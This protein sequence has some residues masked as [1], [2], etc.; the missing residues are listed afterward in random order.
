MEVNEWAALVDVYLPTVRMAEHEDSVKQTVTL[1]AWLNSAA[2]ELGSTS[3]RCCKDA[4]KAAIRS[5]RHSAG[6]SM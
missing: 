6:H 1:P 2:Q 4:L 5:Q 3:L